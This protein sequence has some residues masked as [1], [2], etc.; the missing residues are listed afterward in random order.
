MYVRTLYRKIPNLRDLSI[1]YFGIVARHTLGSIRS[2]RYVSYR[3][4]NRVA[5]RGTLPPAKTLAN[6]HHLR[7]L[8]VYVCTRKCVCVRD[9]F[10]EVSTRLVRQAHL[11]DRFPQT[12]SHLSCLRATVPAHGYKY[13]DSHVS[14]SHCDATRP[15]VRKAVGAAHTIS[16]RNQQVRTPVQGH[17]AT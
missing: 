4:K 3:E 16:V 7:F 13:Y 14:I 2:V 17:S 6:I 8:R 5:Y 12:T 1:R 11:Y 9:I 10:K 15:R